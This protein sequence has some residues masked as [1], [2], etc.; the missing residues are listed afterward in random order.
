MS[1]PTGF[2]RPE[3]PTPIPVVIHRGD[4]GRGKHGNRTRTVEHGRPTT[5]RLS[6]D[7]GAE[8]R[9]LIFQRKEKAPDRYASVAGLLRTTPRRRL[10]ENRLTAYA[11]A[12]HA[13]IR[14]GLSSD[15]AP[16]FRLPGLFFPT[17]FGQSRFRA[18]TRSIGSPDAEKRVVTR[19]LVPDRFSG[20]RRRHV[21][22]RALGPVR[23]YTCT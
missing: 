10:D 18:R 20:E 16:H 22:T 9:S 19:R 14:L 23:V 7:V 1:A 21:F 13:R 6:N 8:W 5:G 4:T 2:P 17:A 12:G 15:N 3:K 11:V